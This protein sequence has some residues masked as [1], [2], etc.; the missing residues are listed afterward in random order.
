MP[1]SEPETPDAEAVIEQMSA[2]VNTQNIDAGEV[3]T[4]IDDQHNYLQNEMFTGI[5]KQVIIGIA[6]TDSHDKRNEHAYRQAEEIVDHMNWE[7]PE[8]R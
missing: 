5:I 7:I 2:A 3:H 8:N 4:A 1:P 6:S